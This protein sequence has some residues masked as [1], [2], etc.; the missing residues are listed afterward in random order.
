MQAL[1]EA[2]GELLK[3]QKLAPTPNA[4]GE[5]HYIGGQAK[6]AAAVSLRT[7]DPDRFAIINSA[8]GETLEEIEACCAFFEVYDGACCAFFEGCCVFLESYCAFLRA[9]H[10]LSGAAHS[11]RG[12]AHSLR[13]AMVREQLLSPRMM[14]QPLPVVAWPACVWSRAAGAVYM[15]HGRPFL[16]TSLD[17][18]GRVAH[19]TPSNVRY[20]TS[21]V[22]HR[23]VHVVGG[24]VAYNAAPERSVCKPAARVAKALVTLRYSAFVRTARGSGITF[25]ALC[26]NDLQPCISLKG[27]P[28]PMVEFIAR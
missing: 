11:L 6:P 14:A 7:I 23:H 2:C 21:P 12:A 18:S 19:V 1:H 17:L 5:L 28:V 9:A 4:P 27:S 16:C 26:P 22:N 25:G 24:H 3:A 10:S 13:S 8:T 20:Y 15:H